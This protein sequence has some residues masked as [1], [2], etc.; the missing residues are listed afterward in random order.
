MMALGKYYEDLSTYFA[1][2]A[3]VPY[4]ICCYEQLNL[5]LNVNITTMHTNLYPVSNSTKYDKRIALSFPSDDS[6][7]STEFSFSIEFILV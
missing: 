3:S 4:L 1:I 7:F 2:C 5:K 6:V